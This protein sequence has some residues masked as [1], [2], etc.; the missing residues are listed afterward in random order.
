M[1]SGD[2]LS[3]KLSL[4]IRREVTS[5]SLIPYSA[6][7]QRPFALRIEF[8]PDCYIVAHAHH[9]HFTFENGTIFG[10]WNF[11]ADDA[12]GWGP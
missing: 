3:D 10:P 1:A 2:M 11:G 8:G 6:K 12:K 7:D 4:L 5:V 9:L